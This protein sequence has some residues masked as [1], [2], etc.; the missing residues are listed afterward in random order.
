[1]KRLT[2][3]ND[4]MH[5]INIIQILKSRGP[6]TVLHEIPES[7]P[8]DHTETQKYKHGTVRQISNY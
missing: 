4:Y 6:K 8:K 3:H 1:M 7:T 5:S 2:E